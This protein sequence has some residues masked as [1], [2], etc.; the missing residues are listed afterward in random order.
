M[1]CTAR[2]FNCVRCH[3]RVIICSRCDR[4]QIYCASD[5]AKQA[6]KHHQQ[7][8][9]DRYRLS[10]KGRL[11]NALRQQRHRSRIQ[12]KVTEHGSVQ[13]PFVDSLPDKTSKSATTQNTTC[14]ATHLNALSCHFCARACDEYV[15]RGFL[16]RH[17]STDPPL[18][19]LRRTDTT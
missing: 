4:G 12:Q 6:R 10:R 7:S 19:S 8:S 17:S 18:R 5:C 15:R 1:L 3:T 11:N 9:R 16:R 14:A 13:P 2:H